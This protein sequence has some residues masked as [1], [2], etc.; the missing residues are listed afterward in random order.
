MSHII[1]ASHFSPQC[2]YTHG[3]DIFWFPEWKFAA[4]VYDL[5]HLQKSYNIRSGCCMCVHYKLY[6][7]A[8]P[9][10]SY[11]CIYANKYNN[12]SI[13]EGVQ[14]QAWLHS[15]GKYLGQSVCLHYTDSPVCCLQTTFNLFIMRNS[16]AYLDPRSEVRDECCN[17]S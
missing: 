16:N 9:V 7:L 14:L 10:F 6:L 2:Y 5:E 1:Q 3:L 12:V 13:T 17:G 8:F 4:A 15:S 11:L